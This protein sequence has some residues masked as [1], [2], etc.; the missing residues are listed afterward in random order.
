MVRYSKPKEVPFRP[1]DY[2]GCPECG[3]YK[4]PKDRRL[5]D[6]YWFCLKHVQEYNKNWDFYKGLSPEEIEQHLQHDQTWQRPTWRMGDKETVRA[7]RVKDKYGFFHSDHLGM[8]GKYVPPPALKVHK[9]LQDALDFLEVRL[10]CTISEVK[11]KYKLLAKRYHPDVNG[12]DKEATK[13]FLKLQKAY[14]EIIKYLE[15]K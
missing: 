11:K 13:R 6:Y 1:C 4:A 5:Q 8:S 7:D 2:P 10:P 14:E 3:S 9:K 15:Y 12:G